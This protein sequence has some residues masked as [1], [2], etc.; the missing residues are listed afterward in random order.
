[1]SHSVDRM[2]VASDRIIEVCSRKSSYES[3]ETPIMVALPSTFA[4]EIPIMVASPSA[5][6]LAESIEIVSAVA[7]EKLPVFECPYVDDDSEEN[8]LGDISQVAESSLITSLA[9]FHIQSVE[10]VR[11]LMIESVWRDTIVRNWLQADGET[12]D[13]LNVSGSE[14]KSIAVVTFSILVT[15]EGWPPPSRCFHMCENP[16]TKLEVLSKF[17]LSLEVRNGTWY[18][19]QDLDLF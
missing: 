13:Q 17:R 9:D 14:K 11:L 6:A 10:K 2:I 16:L 15:L 12:W 8:H 1:M 4:P 5:C 3:P 19:I 7:D 18:N